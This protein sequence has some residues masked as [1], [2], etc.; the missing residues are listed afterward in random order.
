MTDRKN[1]ALQIYQSNLDIV[2]HAFINEDYETLRLYLGTPGYICSA[3]AQVYLE[4]QEQ[5]E[6]TIGVSLRSVRAMGAD[7]YIRI[8]RSADFEGP[9]ADRIVG[10]HETFILRKGAPTIPPYMNAMTLTLDA[11]IWRAFGLFSNVS[12]H[13]YRI[14]SLEDAELT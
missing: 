3:E 4:T 14:L 13:D 11:G 1:E 2:S 7:A 12:V 10:E 5:L 8:C 6:R 9:N